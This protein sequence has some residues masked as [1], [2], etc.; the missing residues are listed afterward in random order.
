M[1][2]TDV[3]SRGIGMI[4]PPSPIQ[5]RPVA[6][7][8]VTLL[9]TLRRFLDCVILPGFFRVFWFSLIRCLGTARAAYFVLRS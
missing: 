9:S 8:V 5:Q 6:Y 1:V 7:T 2:A 3:A 4:K